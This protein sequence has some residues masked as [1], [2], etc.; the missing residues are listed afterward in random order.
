M[1]TIFFNANG[2]TGSASPTSVAFTSGSITTASQGTLAKTDRKFIGW[3]NNTSGTGL[4]YRAASSASFSSATDTTLYAHWAD[5]TEFI[6]AKVYYYFRD[7]GF[8][9]AQASG[10][11]G[12]IEQESSWNP[13][14]RGSSST[15]YWGLVQINS[16]LANGL[17]T[18]YKDAGLDMTKYGYSVST[19][20]A[21]GAEK[22]IP[23]ADLEII[24]KTQLDYIYGCKP[25]DSDWIT[26]VTA[27]A[28][29]N[30]ATEAFL[31]RFEGATTTSQTEDNKIKYFAPALNKY[32]Q[33]TSQRR[34][35]AAKY[36]SKYHY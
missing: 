25:T 8:T 14:R 27:A 12:N 6:K 5:R 32:Y 21:L 16:T 2:G 28:S 15:Q 23:F 20:W 22:D 11:M 30:E 13:L 35:N 10:V 18:K 24:I 3:T 19:Y 17:N 1:A 9:K 4:S 34:T 26:P 36:E 29:A 33:E 31:V 7:K